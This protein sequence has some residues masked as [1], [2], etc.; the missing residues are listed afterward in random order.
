MTWISPASSFGGREMMSVESVFRVHPRACLIIL[1]RTL[2][3]RHGYRILKPLIDG[4]FK[5]QAVTPDLLFLFKGTPAEAWLHELRKGKKD[6]G[7][8]PLSQNLSNLIRLAVLYK[9]GGVYID[10]RHRFHSS[11][12]LNYVEEF[13]W[14]TKHG[15]GF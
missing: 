4:G 15:F 8:I 6:P 13:Y 2:D 9:Y 14:C 5:V 10:I 12:T 3:T 1:S 11:K 7:E